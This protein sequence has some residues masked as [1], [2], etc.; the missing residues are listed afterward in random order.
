MLSRGFRNIKSS[1]M[2]P[3]RFLQTTTGGETK[4]VANEVGA[5]YHD[6]LHRNRDVSKIILKIQ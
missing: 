6:M 5:F 4:I 1:V 2:T 3:I